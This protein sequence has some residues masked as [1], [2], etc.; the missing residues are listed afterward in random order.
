MNYFYTIFQSPDKPDK[1]YL[2]AFGEYI[3]LSVR[4]GYNLQ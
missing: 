1:S 2:P 4:S 3:R